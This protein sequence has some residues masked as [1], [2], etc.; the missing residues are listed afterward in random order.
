MCNKVVWRHSHRGSIR[1]Y[2]SIVK[3]VFYYWRQ[4]LNLS[5]ALLSSRRETSWRS[6]LPQRFVQRTPLIL[7][8]WRV[9]SPKKS[10][11]I[12]EYQV[13][14]RVFLSVGSRWFWIYFHAEFYSKCH[15]DTLSIYAKSG[16]LSR[17]GRSEV[18]RNLYDN[19]SN[20]VCILGFSN[21]FCSS[22]LDYYYVLH[23]F[24]MQRSL[25]NQS[26]NYQVPLLYGNK[27][28]L[29]EVRQ[30]I[31]NHSLPELWIEG[32]ESRILAESEK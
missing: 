28:R 24:W 15:N 20:I 29:Y 32:K 6:C 25:G 11:A 30:E 8:M 12:R 19:R 23:C 26:T 14:Y 17:A 22:D 27:I 9:G 31:W 1:L 16:S 3:A 10:R 21:H 4:F 18:D 13:R 5:T 2:L 7:H